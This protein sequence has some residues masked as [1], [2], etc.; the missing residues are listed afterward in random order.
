[1][2]KKKKAQVTKPVL[3]HHVSRQL[4]PSSHKF[5]DS[6]ESFTALTSEHLPLVASQR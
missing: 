3:L 4:S 6:V 5:P 1:M 2:N